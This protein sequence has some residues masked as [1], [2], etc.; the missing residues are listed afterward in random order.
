[1][2]SPTNPRWTPSGLTR[3]S[4]R[5]IELLSGGERWLGAEKAQLAQRPDANFRFAQDRT[6]FDRAEGARVAR[7]IAVVAHDEVLVRGKQ[8]GLSRFRPIIV[9]CPFFRKVGLAK[10]LTVDVDHAVRDV[11]ALTRQRDDPLDEIAA[12]FV[13]GFENPVVA[14]LGWE[15]T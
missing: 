12:G 3:T 6:E 10:H 4:V 15:G 7:M 11:N 8:L 9:V 2:I 1:M 5:C 13:G 14:A